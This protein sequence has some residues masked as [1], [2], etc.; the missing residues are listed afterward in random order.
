MIAKLTNPRFLL[1]VR[2]L[3]PVALAE[4]LTEEVTVDSFRRMSTNLIDRL[5]G[6]PRGRTQAM[7]ERVGFL[8]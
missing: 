6:E 8:W 4:A 7:K 3:L 1:D 5:S 2:I